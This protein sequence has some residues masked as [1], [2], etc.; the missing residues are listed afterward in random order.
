LAFCFLSFASFS[1]RE[2]LAFLTFPEAS[3]AVTAT[4][5]LTFRPAYLRR[6]FF[7]IVIRTGTDAPGATTL[8]PVLTRI[9]IGFFFFFFFLAVSAL[10]L[11]ACFRAIRQRRGDRHRRGLVAADR[12]LQR[13]ARAAAAAGTVA[14]D[15]DLA[16]R[17][18]L[19]RK[20]ASD[21]ACG[22]AA[23]RAPSLLK[24]TNATIVSA[25]AF[26]PGSL[27]VAWPLPS[28]VNAA[29]PGLAPVI[30][31]FSERPA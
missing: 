25:P 27:I 13:L 28:S 12:Y 15:L 2:R 17:A 18:M 5:A 10:A 7:E 19:S 4:V 22:S 16:R 30:V 8:V 9:L 11:R 29:P 3:V 6:T 31:Y 23:C 14:A 24:S 21:D 26:A 20:V 1:E